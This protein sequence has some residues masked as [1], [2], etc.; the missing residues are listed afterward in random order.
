[1]DFL[2]KITNP[3]KAIKEARQRDLKERIE[4]LENMGKMFKDIDESGVLNEP[5]VNQENVN[6]V[7]VAEAEKWMK[8]NNIKDIK[9]R[10]LKDD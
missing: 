8:E 5:G 1:M 4:H 2:S 10:L 7:L 3:I 9:G 6:D